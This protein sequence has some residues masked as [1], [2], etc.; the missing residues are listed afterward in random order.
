MV[1]ASS[2]VATGGAAEPF[3]FAEVVGPADRLQKIIDHKP[4][5]DFWLSSDM[6]ANVAGQLTL[7][8]YMRGQTLISG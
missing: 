6:R 8:C 4:V 5:R 1:R 3:F 2:K 7:C